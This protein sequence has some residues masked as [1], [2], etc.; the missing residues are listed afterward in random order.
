M[1]LMRKESMLGNPPALLAC[2]RTVLFPACKLIVA[3]GEVIHVAHAP[4]PANAKLVCVL[5]FTNTFAERASDP[6]A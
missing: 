2:N 4:V 6:L 5:P 3:A 1:P